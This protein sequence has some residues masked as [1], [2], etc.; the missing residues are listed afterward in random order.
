M[1]I[2][3]T[4]LAA[5]KPDKNNPRIGKAYSFLEAYSKLLDNYGNKIAILAGSFVE[6][7]ILQN[8]LMTVS[9]NPKNPEG[10][11]VREG[12]R[13][14]TALQL[15]TNP[16]LRSELES[17]VSTDQAKFCLKK[18][19]SLSKVASSAILTNL[20]VFLETDEETIIHYR[21]L[22]HGGE[23]GGAGTVGWSTLERL[24]DAQPDAPLVVML[25]AILDSDLSDGV[26]AR[27]SENAATIERFID[28]PEIVKRIGLKQNGT[29]LVPIRGKTLLT[30]AVR[31]LLSRIGISSSD[32]IDTRTANTVEQRH[33]LL[34]RFPSTAK[35]GK[36]E[37]TSGPPNQLPKPKPPGVKS[38]PTKS[39]DPTQRKYVFLGDE[40]KPKND[41]CQAIYRELCQL[42]V[43]IFVNSCAFSLRALLEMSV[44][45]F[46]K[47]KELEIC[48]P[49]GEQFKL[50]ARL[51]IVSDELKKINPKVELGQ[52]AKLNH[53][54]A[55]MITYL[56]AFV[57]NT[58]YYPNSKD[59]IG[60]GDALKPFLAA[61]WEHIDK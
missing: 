44:D 32:R 56:N 58:S 27:C 21:R 46:A 26:K 22:R 52:V 4:T 55:G 6:R 13:R 37:K 23:L 20:T 57:H 50:G 30:Q 48:K 12:N 18:I 31:E 14:L 39:K 24:R 1:T 17:R 7:G 53:G 9:P 19:K 16:A 29:T 10:Y 42:N 61:I 43:E 3:P 54:K 11:I 49:S 36:R 28:Q 25:D 47:R 15:L 41:R 59:L 51:K 60:F 8:E 2:I 45:E 40:F 34:D 33:D 35:V 38:K 5:L